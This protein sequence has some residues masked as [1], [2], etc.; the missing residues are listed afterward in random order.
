M[1][2]STTAT[3]MASDTR[4]AVTSRWVQT[5]WRT[6]NPSLFVPKSPRRTWLNQNQ[7]RP[8]KPALRCS[9]AS[10]ARMTARGTLGRNRRSPRGSPE[11][12]PR[13]KANSEARTS[14]GIEMRIRRKVKRRTSVATPPSPGAGH[15]RPPSG[16]RSCC[17]SPL[18][19]RERPLVHAERRTHLGDVVDHVLVLG[20][21]DEQGGLLEERQRDHVLPEQGVH[22]VVEV[23]LLVVV[24]LHVG[25]LDEGVDRGVR[26]RIV[27]LAACGDGPGFVLD[28]R[29]EDRVVAR[30]VRGVD[31]GEDD[32]VEVMGAERRAEAGRVLLRHRDAEGRQGVDDV[33]LLG[34]AELVA[35]GG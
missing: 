20:L 1:T 25:L 27:V 22:L 21:V 31:P 35:L 6:G 16:G 23:G 33:G 3:T 19:L 8:K 18:L 24:E 9:S 15:D 30:G 34:V 2:A 5:M 10:L 4:R 29:L 13:T 28:L 17:S 11:L 14:T 7:Y 26:V 32:H 12:I